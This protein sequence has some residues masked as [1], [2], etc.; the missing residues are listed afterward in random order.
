MSSIG[1]R[2]CE[3]IMKEKRPCHTKLCDFRCLISRPQ[4]L[5]LRSQNQIREKLLL[6]RKLRYFRGSRFS[7]VLYYQPLPITGYQVRW[8]IYGHNETLLRQKKSTII[9]IIQ[10]RVCHSLE[11]K[12]VYKPLPKARAENLQRSAGIFYH[13]NLMINGGGSLSINVSQFLLW[14][15]D[16]GLES[17]IHNN[18]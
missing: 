12:Y 3:I 13:S 5:N 6:S 10:T 11:R 14:Q 7:H 2:S 8:I 17:G 1:G 4:I 18:P 9:F 16:K 15:T